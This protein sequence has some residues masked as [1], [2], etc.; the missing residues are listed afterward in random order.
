MDKK[1]RRQ[2]EPIV[3]SAIVVTK[4]GKINEPS[5]YPKLKL[6]YLRIS[7][8]EIEKLLLQSRKAIQHRQKNNGEAN[9]E[10][11]SDRDVPKLLP[12]KLQRTRQLHL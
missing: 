10:E 2:P 11:T 12:Q 3:K 7:E 5:V 4:D 6:N 1:Q 9:D 8:E